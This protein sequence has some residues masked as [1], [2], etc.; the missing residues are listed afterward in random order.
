VNTEAIKAQIF[1]KKTWWDYFLLSIGTFLLGYAIIAFWDEWSLVTGGLSGLA[2]IVAEYSYQVGFYIPIWLTNFALNIPLL[3][4]GYFIIPM[5]YFL[6]TVYASQFLT[7]A[8]WVSEFLPV[9][10]SNM[11]LGTVFGGV[12]AGIGLGLVFRANG[13]TGGTTLMAEII[14]RKILKHV[15]LATILFGVDTTIILI[16]FLVFG[17]INTMY[18]IIGIFVCARVTD[19]MIEGMSFS[20]ATFIISKDADIISQAI[21]REMNRG[22]T[23]IDSHG[24]FTKTPQTMLLCVVPAKQIVHLK[25][26]VYAHDEKA[27]V[28]VADVREVLGEGFKIGKDTL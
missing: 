21:L 1:N 5:R 15:S 19:V 28:I 13:T 6:R 14:K 20:K 7:F 27:F 22:C 12:V 24:M 16:G 23:A 9:P 25:D 11:L 18:A 2:I 4:L 10:E 8:L 3:V 17:P 26:I